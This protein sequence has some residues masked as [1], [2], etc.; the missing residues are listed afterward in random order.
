MHRASV[1]L[2]PPELP[3]VMRADT[4]ITT[5]PAHVSPALSK[6]LAPSTSTACEF[7]NLFI[8]LKKLISFF[9]SVNEALEAETLE[10]LMENKLVREKKQEL[11]R[12]LEALRKKQDKERQRLTGDPDKSRAKYYTNKLVKRLSSKNMDLGLSAHESSDYSEE[13]T[14]RA[15][16]SMPRSQSERLLSA[17]R[18]HVNQERDIREKYMESIFAT[19]EKLMKASQAHQIKVLRAVQ[20][21]ETADMM[22]KLQATRREEVKALSK[23]HKDKDEMVRIK[24]EVDSAMVEKG[25]R[26]RERLT[27]LYERKRGDLERQHEQVRQS[28]ED[29]KARVS[30]ML[31]SKL[32]F[33]AYFQFSVVDKFF[34]IMIQ[35]VLGWKRKSRHR[36]LRSFS[37]L[38]LE[39]LRLFISSQSAKLIGIELLAVQIEIFL[40]FFR[41][42]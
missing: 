18:E 34:E 17:C 41:F 36:R 24:R 6:S 26:E 40:L 14:A 10:K 16:G 2:P 28:L 1:A 27:S 42:R 38:Q 15:G 31:L 35:G 32:V 9:F 33:F 4:D 30:F 3:E 13:E 21:R 39:I 5:E 23:V 11:E 19:V 12:K 20:E 8:F 7:S 37:R 22:R 25:V 29:E